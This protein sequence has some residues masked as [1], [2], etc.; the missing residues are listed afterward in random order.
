MIFYRQ[1][2]SGDLFGLEQAVADAIQIPVWKCIK[3]Q[4]HPPSMACGKK[5]A[6]ERPTHCC[7]CKNPIL[8]KSRDGL[9]LLLDDALIVKCTGVVTKDAARPRVEITLQTIEPDQAA[10]F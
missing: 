4:A 8:K 1:V 3:T 5:T 10:L 9:G 2:N 6:G 7:H